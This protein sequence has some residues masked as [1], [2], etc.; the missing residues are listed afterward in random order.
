MPLTPLAAR[1]DQFILDLDG[2]VWVGGEPTP[3]AAEALEAL[4]D[5]GKR[6]AFATNNAYASG[7]DYVTQLWRI[8]VQASLARRGDRRRRM[9]HVLAD[10]RPGAPPS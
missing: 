4:R 7:E 10:T 9:Q 5:A 2:C 6:L 3:G 8:G 1:Y